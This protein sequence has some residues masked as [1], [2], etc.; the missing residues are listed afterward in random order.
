MDDYLSVLAVLAMAIVFAVGMISAR[1]QK[2]SRSQT[3]LDFAKSRP[4]DLSNKEEIQLEM[5]VEISL[6]DKDKGR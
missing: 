6:Q 5:S 2:K 1:I 3:N 4:E